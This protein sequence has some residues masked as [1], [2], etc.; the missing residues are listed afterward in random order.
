M[1]DRFQWYNETLV[2]TW[3]PSLPSVATAQGELMEHGVCMLQSLLND[4]N[5]RTNAGRDHEEQPAPSVESRPCGCEESVSL[6]HDLAAVTRR[7]AL[8][9]DVLC[10]HND[11]LPTNVK[12]QLWNA[13]HDGA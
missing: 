3:H 9:V 8:A 4:W 2:D 7:I 13:L 12:L 1:A 6:R 10:K 11:D 5:A